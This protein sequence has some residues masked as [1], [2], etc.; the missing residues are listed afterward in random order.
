[1]KTKANRKLFYWLFKALSVTVACALPVWGVCSKFPIWVEEYGT[2]RSLGVGGIIGI[3]VLLIVFRRTIFDFLKDKWKLRYA[4]PITVWIVMI[5]ISYVL[6]FVSKFLY[7]ITTVFW[8]GLIGSAT[9]AIFTFVG[10]NLF[11]EENKDE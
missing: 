9:G 8:M 10:E 7:D 4:P 11:G 5:L 6:M 3:V 2:G 1:M